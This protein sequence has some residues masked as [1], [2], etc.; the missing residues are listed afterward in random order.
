M[1]RRRIRLAQN[2]LKDPGLVASLVAG[3]SL[4]KED[5]VYEIGPDQGIITR[6]LA[7]RRPGRRD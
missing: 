1:L 2:F 6:E 4:H 3:S 7:A 5:V